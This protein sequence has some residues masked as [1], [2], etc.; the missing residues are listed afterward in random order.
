MD[1]VGHE[2]IEWIAALILV[3]GGALLVAIGFRARQ[4]RRG[5][6]AAARRTRGAAGGGADSRS[7]AI[8]LAV[9]SA[10]GAAIH[11]AA[12]PAHY[13][14]IGDLASGFVVA[15]IFQ[16]GWIRPCLAGLSRRAAWVGIAGN[17]AIVLAWAWSRTIGLPAGQVSGTPE[18]IG[19]PDGASVA[20]E[21]VLVA[22]LVARLAGAGAAL[23]RRVELRTAASIAVVPVVGLVLILTSLSAVAIAGGLEHGPLPPHPMSGHVPAP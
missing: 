3:V 18:P 19:L 21:L 16:A 17:L 22:V 13:A 10:G 8:T 5:S 9:L 14:E 7:V 11:L 15:A 6:A 1:H 23:G 4:V 20:F 2:G 12:A